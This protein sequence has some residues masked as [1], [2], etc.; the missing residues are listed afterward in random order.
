MLVVLSLSGLWGRSAKKCRKGH[1]HVGW[2]VEGG[3]INAPTRFASK[4]HEHYHISPQVVE[5]GK[6][7]FDAWMIDI[8]VAFGFLIKTHS[9]KQEN[10]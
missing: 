10:C 1:A 2:I 9:I 7:M 4:E 3:S 5:N 8:T 6:E